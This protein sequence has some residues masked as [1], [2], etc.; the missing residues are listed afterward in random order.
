MSAA[1][2]GDYEAAEALANDAE[3]AAAPLGI[4]FAEVQ[5]ARGINALGAGRYDDA[6]RHLRRMFDPRDDAYHPMR[7]CFF[8]GDLA[9][10]AVQSGH[11]DDAIALRAEMEALASR[12]PSPQF[13]LAMLHARAVLADD[14]RAPRLFEAALAG[15]AGHSPF[16]MARLRLAFGAWLRRARRVKEA[17]PLLQSAMEGFDAL[18]ALPWSERARQELRAAGATIARRVPDRQE[19]LTP[20]ELQIALMA[21]QGLT[22]REIGQ[23]M[24]LSHRTVGSHL[25]RIYPK[26]DITS[27]F[28]LRDALASEGTFTSS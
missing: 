7:H 27:R 3:R 8:I 4:L 6:Y 12:T 10:A 17:R 15:G 18:G 25:Y 22:N 21:A 13:Q 16:T 26:L 2:R 24:Y 14:T 20:Q 5:M 11:R 23:R 19:E 9:E 1:L 28:Q